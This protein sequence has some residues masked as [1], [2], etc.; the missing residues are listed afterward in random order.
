MRCTTDRQKFIILTEQRTG[1]CHLEYLLGSHETAKVGGEIFN[2]SYRHSAAVAL[3][4]GFADLRRDDPIAYVDKFFSQNFSD[5]T[6]HVGFR[7][8]YNHGRQNGEEIIW[9]H[10]QNI[11]NLKIVHLQRNNLLKNFLSL[12]LAQ[13]EKVWMRRKGDPETRYKSIPLDS[14]ECIKHF[15]TREYNI[16]H[17]DHFFRKNPRIDVIYEALANR[18]RQE[19]ERLLNFL[20]LEPQILTNKV[21]K[22]NHQRLPEL[23]SN[24]GQLKASFRHTKWEHFFDE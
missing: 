23:I 9:A 2:P 4:Q 14:D 10:L 5:L 20:G 21:L 17:F 24:Y 3:V 15:E 8:F 12:K 18:E 19:T 13:R 7:L 22:Q 16:E 11:K 6:T 1:S